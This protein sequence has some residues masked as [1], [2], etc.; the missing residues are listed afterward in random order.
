[1]CDASDYALGTG[2]GQRVEKHFQPNYFASKTL[3]PAHEN[4]TTTEKEL[5]VVVYA[6]DKFHTYLVLSK[7]IGFTNHSTL[8]YLS[9]MFDVKPILI[10]WVLLL[11]EFDIEIR[12][13]KRNGE[14]GSRPLIKT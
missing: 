1:M 5:L 13:K 7:T 2:F 9:A 10:R 12:D 11:Q 4:Y 14:H 8:K 6:F 3:Y